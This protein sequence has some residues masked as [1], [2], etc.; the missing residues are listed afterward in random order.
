MPAR[1]VILTILI[2]MFLCT[3]VHAPNFQ[4][5]EIWIH[6][7]TFDL[8]IG[9]RA[10][11][12]YYTVKV[13]D[14]QTEG[15]DPSA[16][17]LVYLNNNYKEIFFTDV[18][19]NN[20]HVYDGELKIITTG[21]V[22]G[23]V[24]IELY[25][26]EYEKV[27]ILDVN[28]TRLGVDEILDITD[29]TILVSS[30]E[31]NNVILEVNNDGLNSTDIYAQGV[32][33]KYSEQF[34]VRVVYVD[35]DTE[36]AIIEVYRPGIP[37]LQIRI[38]GIK[39]IYNQDEDIQFEAVVENKGTLPVRGITVTTSSSSGSLDEPHQTAPIIDAF[40]DLQFPLSIIPPTTP[41]GKNVTLNARVE[42]YDHKG[43]AYSNSTIQEI[44]V[45]PYLSIAKTVEHAQIAL[46]SADGKPD[47]LKVHLAVTNRGDLDTTI[48]VLDRVPASFLHSDM[49]SLDW[50]FVIR[51]YSSEDITYTAIPTHAGIFEL[52]PAVVTWDTSGGT[53]SISSK[54]LSNVSVEGTRL[55]VE[56]VLDRDDIFVGESVDLTIR[57][58]NE[59][60]RDANIS[61]SDSLPQQVQL[62]EGK[63][64]WD[65]HLPSQ[66]VIEL[67]YTAEVIQEGNLELPAVEVSY[68]DDVGQTG[69]V[70]SSPLILH[71][72]EN[73]IAA[74]ETPGTAEE[75]PYETPITEP[76]R[77]GMTKFL[78][79][80]FLTLFCVLSIVPVTLYLYI[81]RIR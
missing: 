20:E 59:G 72:Y 62:I 33:R 1:N 25:T 63:T 14:I 50:S 16:R 56:K 53:Y 12:E 79:S 21:I 37:E 17:L 13:H 75:I 10:S 32:V 27:W 46:E 8:A 43:N 65:G 67:T 35:R 7:G 23:K 26:H 48:H 57:I 30:I 81:T 70:R 68:E 78:V 55:V 40:S 36:E 9:E 76:T 64:G 29:A 44:Y 22:E 19:A 66:G 54:R 74:S 49:P 34:M 28:R 80:S 38:T 18:L 4:Y 52:D 2:L 6:Q 11:A 39:D 69:M 24:S 45:N 60:T 58:R 15:T 77:W 42:G 61:F 5:E 73:T 41:T 71:T 3:P 51:A 47:Q 31:G